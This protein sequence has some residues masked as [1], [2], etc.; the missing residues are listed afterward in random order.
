MKNIIKLGLLL[1]LILSML[2]VGC[3]VKE[4]SDEETMSSEASKDADKDEVVEETEKEDA[5][6]KKD[7]TDKEEVQDQSIDEGYKERLKAQADKE[8][9]SVKEFQKTLDGLIEVGA[10]KYGVT[11][12]EYILSLEV[13]NSTVLDEW[14]LAS[15]VMGVSITELYEYEKQ[16][17]NT[18]TD[19]EEEIMAGMM[20]A[21][22]EASAI[23]LDQIEGQEDINAL[24]GITE[25]TSGEIVEVSGDFKE[26]FYYKADVIDFEYEDE[27]SLTVE[28]FSNEDTDKLLEYYTKL[29]ENTENYMLLAPVG[30]Q[31]GMIQGHFNEMDVYVDIDNEDGDG[32]TF[33]NCYLDFTSKN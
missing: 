32:Q 27:Y 1:V 33:V 17:A 20:N 4:S 18:R 16:S 22:D 14:I 13:N 30:M 2:S 6:D 26:V 31:G 28:Y 3:G 23:D 10:L 8:G 15:E 25:N 5:A 12:E 19:E 11:E 7:A 21:L 29:L 24:L 9:V